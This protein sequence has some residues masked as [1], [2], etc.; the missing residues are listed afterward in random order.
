MK[1]KPGFVVSKVGGKTVAVASGDLCKE[2]NGMITLKSSGELLFNLLKNDVDEDTLSQALKKEYGISDE[3]AR[4][5]VCT[6][7]SG[8]KKAG[9]LE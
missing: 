3:Q 8:L 7:L 2:F 6:F 5:D 9:L 4:T 1:I